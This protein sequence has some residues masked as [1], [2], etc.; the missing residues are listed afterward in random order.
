MQLP[1]QNKFIPTDFTLIT[2]SEKQTKYPEL[3]RGDM[4]GE[5]F[6]LEDRLFKLPKV[7]LDILIYLEG[8]KIFGSARN[9][10]GITLFK[11]LLVVY[12]RE[13]LY[14]AQIANIN[15]NFLITT[16]GFRFKFSSYNDRLDLFVTELANKIGEF[17]KGGKEVE[18][19]L[20][21]F[22]PLFKTKRTEELE[23]QKK[24]EPY[25]QYQHL[26]SE[27]FYTNLFS[28]E[29]LLKELETISFEDYFAI[30]KS[31][32]SKIYTETL[33]NGN[34][35]KSQALSIEKNFF[36]TL[37][38]WIPIGELPINKIAENRVITLNKQSIKIY[39][40]KLVNPKDQNNMMS[41]SFQLTQ[42]KSLKYIN[43]ILEDF[44]SN[45]Y[46]SEIREKQQ[47]GYVVFAFP[48]SRKNVADFTFLIQSEKL[49][50]SDLASKTYQFLDMIQPKM[51]SITDKKFEELREGVLAPYKQEFNSLG[52]QTNFFLNSIQNHSYDFDS[53]EKGI[54]ILNSISKEDL[55]NHFQ[56]IFFEDRK[57]IEFHLMNESNFKKNSEDLDK[58][59]NKT[60][61]GSHSFE[62][63]PITVYDSA[64]ELQ[65]D[66][67]LFVDTSLK[68]KSFENNLN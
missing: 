35:N 15:V 43:S 5:L 4:K 57:V 34:L 59:I 63:L 37:S 17:I 64:S 39:T 54:E 25:K 19:Y 41:M 18:N 21:K 47:L 8:K 2:N 53:K 45:E 58:R 20:Q 60:E 46:F 40:Q 22:Y 10:L 24:E 42:D 29:V 12:L 13:F 48:N 67:M 68:K 52:S 38:E 55:V 16:T 7:Q 9:Y 62:D 49:K 50:P 51:L 56:K 23:N 28:T 26:T 3:I 1:E 65:R 11:Y 66:H 27:V 33:I 36:G 14:T 32:F 61:T 44:L 31:N 30:H 6:F